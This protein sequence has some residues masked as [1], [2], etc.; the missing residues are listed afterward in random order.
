ME[1]RRAVVGAL[2]DGPVP[3]RVLA[4]RL[5]V[6]A[7]DVRDHVEDLRDVG[8][9]VT[10]DE[11]GYHLVGSYG[12]G[13]GAALDVAY[14]VEYHETVSSTNDVARERAGE[15]AAD[16]AVL[17]DRQ[18]GGRGRRD[19]PWVSPPGGIYCSL[20]VRPGLAPDR[21][22]LLTLAAGVAVVRAVEP[23]G[24]R[25]ALKWPNDV[26]ADGDPDRKLGGVLTEAATDA[27][28]VDW[29]IVG[30][31][32]NANAAPD[33]L[34]PGAASLRELTGGRV[35]RGPVTTAVLEAFHGLAAAADRVPDAWRDAAATIGRG[36][37]VRTP[38]GPITGTAVD[39][40]A[41]GALVVETAAGIRR[42]TIGECEH[43][44]PR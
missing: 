37:R 13:V 15:G 6:P 19:G 12:H 10:R 5:G 8:Y 14:D 43:L 35:D 16:L 34:P 27:D 3:P 26:L 41:D 18:T 28:G 40:D 38:T 32:V 1:R 31:G 30:I 4:D 39:V 42:V 33:A 7:T 2:R 20:V 21:I 36:V 9:E 44:R 11:A 17:A 22:P 23:L 25:A 24:V 29:V